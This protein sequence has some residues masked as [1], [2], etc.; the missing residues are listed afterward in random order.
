[1]SLLKPI[2]D[3]LK[4][5]ECKRNCKKRLPILQ[6][7][8]IDDV[9]DIVAGQKELSLK[10]KLNKDMEYKVSIWHSGMPEAFLNHVQE[11]LSAC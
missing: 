10:I 3:G 2:P 11:A 7:P 6:V 1:M 9:Q 4:D 8:V 5:Q